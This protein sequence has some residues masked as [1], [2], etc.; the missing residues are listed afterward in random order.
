MSSDKWMHK[1]NVIYICVCVY[2]YTHIYMCVCIYIYTHSASYTALK[3]KGIL[4]HAVE[5]KFVWLMYS[6]TKLQQRSSEQ[7][8]VYCKGQAKKIDGSCSKDLNSPMVF[9]KAF[10]KATFGVTAAGCMTFFWLVSGEVR[11]YGSRNLIHQPSGSNQ[12][13]VW[14]C[15]CHALPGWEP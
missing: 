15:S 3:R 11:G 14:A 2:I 4:T 9:C 5:P 10:L 8:K 12:S 7:R 6:E 13:G 1:Q